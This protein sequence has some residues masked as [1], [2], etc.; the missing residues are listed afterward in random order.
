MTYMS[1]ILVIVWL[2][3]LSMLLW[4]WMENIRV[5]HNNLGPECADFGYLKPGLISLLWFRFS[6]IE[7]LRL[8][9]V[10]RDRLNGAIWNER[11]MYA[12]MFV[13]VLLAAYL[14]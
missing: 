3:G 2:I 10:G 8:N 12:W 9:S 4:R 11:A 13:G 7:P 14:F 1:A 5:I 6:N